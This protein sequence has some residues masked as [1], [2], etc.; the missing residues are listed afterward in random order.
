MDGFSKG[1]SG[2]AGS[3]GLISD[4]LDPGLKVLLSTLV[5][6]LSVKAELWVVIRGLE[7]ALELED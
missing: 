6:T 4:S 3:G 2:A 1:N 7:L 5:T